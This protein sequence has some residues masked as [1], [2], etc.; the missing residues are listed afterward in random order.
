[1]S[2]RAPLR[3]LLLPVM[4]G[5]LIGLLAAAA[6]LFKAW[7][8]HQHAQR[9]QLVTLQVDALQQALAQELQ[10]LARLGERLGGD[11]PLAAAGRPDL[12]LLARQHRL[13]SLRLLPAPELAVDPQ[14]GV[15]INY[16]VLDLLRR[17]LHDGSAPAE[18]Y[19]IDGQWLLYATALQ[20][21]AS[22]QPVAVLLLVR[23]L[24]QLLER[25]PLPDPQL[26]ELRL[27]QA[28]TGDEPQIL[29]QRG[30]G[31][32]EVLQWPARHPGWLLQFR[33]GP[34]LQPVSADGIAL[35]LAALACI[36]GS[37]LGTLLAIRLQPG[38]S[39]GEGVI[40][41]ARSASTP[42]PPVVRQSSRPA[43]SGDEVFDL[44]D[45]V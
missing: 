45:G 28:Y 2:P 36:S 13:A 29:L 7:Q 32:G 24:M 23:P 38:E 6:L 16:G 12:D 3:R 4:L 1:M 31:E 18:A 30:Q 20:R 25:L 44:S 43:A 37:L 8:Q 17:T 41:P 35:A 22:G 26:G 39:C 10:Q 15:P 40:L 27:L 21:D 34:Q 11:L 42:V 5:S 19:R 33:P 9:Q 14:A